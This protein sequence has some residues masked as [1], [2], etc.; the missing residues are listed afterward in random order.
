MTE[1]AP[2]SPAILKRE[3]LRLMGLPAGGDWPDS[4]T[5]SELARLQYPCDSTTPKEA[6]KLPQRKQRDLIAEAEAAINA[7]ELLT[8]DAIRKVSAIVGIMRYRL[9]RITGERSLRPEY[10]REQDSREVRAIE[11][12]PCAAW[13]QAIEMPPGKYLRAWLGDT[14]REEAPNS[15]AGDTA[16]IEKRKKSALVNECQTVWPSIERDIQDA[17]RN[18]L[19]AAAKL[20]DGRG[21]DKGH[22]LDWAKEKGKLIEEKSASWLEP[23]AILPS[24]ATR[25]R[26]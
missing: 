24:K 9:N 26:R 6:R 5:P 7:G 23:R 20:A 3:A 2:E 1:T 18:G 15:G 12:K 25:R 17:A 19:A 13:L 4:V 14:W 10:H 16:P 11:R 22:A 8:V 21:W